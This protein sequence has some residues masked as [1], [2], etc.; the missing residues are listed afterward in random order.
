[1]ELYQ[2]VEAPKKSKTTMIIG[3]CIAVLLI[4]T[5]AIIFGIIYLKG[6]VMKITIDKQQNNEIEKIIYII[7]HFLEEGKRGKFHGYNYR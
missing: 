3:I 1:M 4:M 2:E 6:S 7:R 5:F